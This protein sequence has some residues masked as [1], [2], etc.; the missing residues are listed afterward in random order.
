MIKEQG[1][2]TFKLGIFVLLGTACLVLGLYYI[3][4][5]KNF[6][7]S[8]I[9]LGAQFNNVGGLTRGNNVRFNGIQVG[10]VSKV[11]AISDR[12]IKV[13]FSVDDQSAHFLTVNSVASI[14]TDGLLGSKLINITAGEKRGTPVK[15]GDVLQ[16]LNPIQMDRALRTLSITND[17]LSAITE[18]L[19]YISERLS[20][21]NSLWNLLSDTIIAAQVKSAV[22]RFN[23]SG[24]NTALLTGD[25]Q[26]IVEHVKNGKGTIGSLLRDTLWSENLNK[27]IRHIEMM[28][29]S[30]QLVAVDFKS[31]STSL[32]NGRGAF[33]RLVMD[34]SFSDDLNAS[35]ENIKWGT[36]NFNQNM[37]ALKG[38]WPFK[39]YFKKLEKAKK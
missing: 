37:E 18:N 3:G 6:F 19:K 4:S 28:S 32:K 25:L 13:E 29:D 33:N 8:T 10:I 23:V 2:N 34:T 21:N 5:K 27:T 31:I 1:V 22:M 20:N 11:Y 26:M 38:V 15:D 39:R 9:Q 17:N 30:L 16:T 7:Q 36:A 12:V 35:M 24:K 14:G